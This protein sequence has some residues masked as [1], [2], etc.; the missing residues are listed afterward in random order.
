[1]MPS[2]LEMYADECAQE[3]LTRQ[4]TDDYLSY[5]E[6]EEFE[7]VEEILKELN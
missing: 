2:T 3:R 6:F 1:M 7:D 5:A 4:M